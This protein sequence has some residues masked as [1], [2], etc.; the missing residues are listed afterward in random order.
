MSKKTFNLQIKDILSLLFRH[1][2]PLWTSLLSLALFG[3]A[4]AASAQSLG[5]SQTPVVKYQEKSKWRE[6]FFGSVR[7]YWGSTVKYQNEH[8]PG[9]YHGLSLGI[10]RQLPQ[11]LKLG[12]SG[13][14]ESNPDAFRKDDPDYR[15]NQYYASD[16]GLTLAASR[17]FQEKTGRSNLSASL[18]AYYPTSRSSREHQLRTAMSAGLGFTT[19]VA[20]LSQDFSVGADAS[21]AKNFFRY[22]EQMTEVRRGDLIGASHVSQTAS[23]R[24][25]FSTALPAGFSLNASYGVMRV[26]PYFGEFSTLNSSHFSLAYA[27]GK[28]Q[29]YATLR[30]AAGQLNHQNDVNYAV[31]ET[32]RTKGELGITYAF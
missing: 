25:L 32:N 17:L 14:I 10:G 30:T 29:P 7:T 3:F 11:D 18:T 13:G 19:P 15:P 6:A 26:Y 8:E 2:R 24:A 1:H 4:E 28:L 23:L 21:F 31:F 20:L 9:A 12:L 16:L 5:M 27:Y 22:T